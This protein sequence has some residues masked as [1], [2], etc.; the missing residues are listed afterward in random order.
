LPDSRQSTTPQVLCVVRVRRGP[1]EFVEHLE[2]VVSVDTLSRSEPRSSSPE[3]I[4]AGELS[5]FTVMMALD[6]ALG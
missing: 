6:N 2:H 3:H 1:D 4:D 5:G